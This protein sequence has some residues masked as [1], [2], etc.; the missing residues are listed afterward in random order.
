M[1]GNARDR[2]P[3]LARQRMDLDR[4]PARQHAL[5]SLRV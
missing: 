5:A 3:G 2:S 4:R 1:A